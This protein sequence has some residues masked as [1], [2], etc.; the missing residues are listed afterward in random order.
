MVYV[1][2]DWVSGNDAAVSVQS[3]ETFAGF[4][5]ANWQE[6]LRKEYF[7]T[8]CFIPILLNVT[9]FVWW[10]I[11]LEQGWISARI[12][13]LRLGRNSSC[14]FLSGHLDHFEYRSFLPSR[15]TAK[16]RG[17]LRSIYLFLFHF[18][19]SLIRK[20]TKLLNRLLENVL[21]KQSHINIWDE[22]LDFR[23]VDQNRKGWVTMGKTGPWIHIF[24]SAAS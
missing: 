8:L 13:L 1:E 21:W 14:P 10:S 24:S 3:C 18:L 6:N 11:Q 2:E 15:D 5:R 16:K 22:T 17:D 23:L 20:T 12:P 7:K 4:G 9:T 19:L